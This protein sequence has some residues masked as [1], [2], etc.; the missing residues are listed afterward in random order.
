LL[1]LWSFRYSLSLI[2]KNANPEMSSQLL[3]PL[4]YPPI[5]SQPETI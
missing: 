4:S 3:L 5:A 1:H 2:M